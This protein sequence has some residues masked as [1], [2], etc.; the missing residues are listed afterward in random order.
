MLENNFK[1]IQHSRAFN[2]LDLHMYAH[3]TQS[4][5]SHSSHRAKHYP[6]CDAHPPSKADTDSFRVKPAPYRPAEEERSNQKKFSL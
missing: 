1:Q 3:V 4:L 6:L 2:N 5:F